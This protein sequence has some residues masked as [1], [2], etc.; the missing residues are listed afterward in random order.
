MIFKLFLLLLLLNIY[1]NYSQSFDYYGRADDEDD[2]EDEVDSF[3]SNVAMEMSADNSD[4]WREDE[5]EEED[6]FKP[7]AVNGGSLNE[8]VRINDGEELKDKYYGRGRER[9]MGGWVDRLV[10]GRM[11]GWIYI[12]IYEW[13]NG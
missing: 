6:E 4:H 5:D 9:W 8:H 2:D 13:M 11:G 12:Y 1:E 3:R 7:Q 10:D